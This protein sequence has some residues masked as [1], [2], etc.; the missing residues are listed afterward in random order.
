MHRG[1]EIIDLNSVVGSEEEHARH[2]RQPDMFQVHS[3]IDRHL[4]IEDSGL[5][6]LDCEA[7]RR[8]RA[9]AVKQGVHH[10]GIGVRG[11]FLDP[12]RLEKWKLF[13]LSFTGVD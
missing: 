8:R 5:A 4:H 1:T 12:E 10:D 13:A 2:G 3:R 7:I 6:E 11:G 9:L